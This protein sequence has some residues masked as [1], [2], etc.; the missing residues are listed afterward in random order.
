[1]PKHPFVKVFLFFV[2]KAPTCDQC[3]TVGVG[4]H[5]WWLWVRVGNAVVVGRGDGWG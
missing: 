4:G 2:V 1:M 3:G 5:E